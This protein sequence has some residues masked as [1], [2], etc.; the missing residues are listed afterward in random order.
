[1][2]FFWLSLASFTCIAAVVIPSPLAVV[3]RRDLG[4]YSTSIQAI[5]TES[6]QYDPSD[7]AKE[8]STNL[9]NLFYA[10]ES[11]N[12]SDYCHSTSMP[13]VWQV[14]VAGKVMTNTKKPEYLDKAIS[15]LNNYRNASGGYSASMSRNGEIY[16]DD[17]AQIAW[18]YAQAYENTKYSKYQNENQNITDFIDGYTTRGG[19]ILWSI[20]GTYIASISTLEEAVAALKLY[21]SKKDSKYL[22]IAKAN[23]NWVIDNLLENSTDFI[24]DG[25]NQDGSINEGKLTYTIGTMISSC[26]YLAYYGDSDRDWKAIG[27]QFGVQFI[28]GGALNNQFFTNGHINDIIER[29]HLLFVGI[30]DLVAMTVPTSSYE[31]DAYQA[32]KRLVTR[33]SRNLYDEYTSVVRN[34][35]CPTNEYQSLLKYSS[36]AQVFYEVSRVVD[37]I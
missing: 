15:A 8:M 33:E 17:N 16:T 5:A 35:S 11:N 14:A 32:F 30:A 34:S 29:S 10:N 6:P 28:A 4:E 2:R 21:S 9:V 18:I 37:K 26:A 3:G 12:W 20:S 13:V 31:Y 1:M 25:M 27:V 7:L 19:G 24:W 22:D 23:V 36:L